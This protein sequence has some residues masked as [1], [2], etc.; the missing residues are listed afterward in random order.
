[1]KHN[2]LMCVLVLMV[3]FGIFSTA[4]GG[5]RNL[6]VDNNYHRH[7]DVAYPQPFHNVEPYRAPQIVVGSSYP[8]QLVYPSRNLPVDPHYRGYQD[9]NFDYSQ[10]QAV[11]VY[12]YNPVEIRIPTRDT[13]RN[14]SRNIP[15]DNDYHRWGDVKYDPTDLRRIGEYNSFDASK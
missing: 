15:V 5:E 12:P 2:A 8:Y 14:P 13:Q 10:V 4:E 11:P 3:G 6:P 9:G 1:M 7:G